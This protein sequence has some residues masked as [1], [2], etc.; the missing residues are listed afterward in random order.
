MA[1]GR[2]LPGPVAPS[3]KWTIL[4]EDVSTSR[5]EA[6]YLFV[7]SRRPDAFDA[8]DERLLR[9][10][11]AHA[12]VALEK[13]RVYAS[14]R[15]D[16]DKV[17]RT[18]SGMLDA[19]ERCTRGHSDRV[20]DHAVAIG[21]EL[22]LPTQDLEMLRFAGLL[23]DIGKLGI[24]EEIILKPTE[25][26]DDE[27]AQVRRHAEIGASLVEQM[28]FLGGIAPVILHH[29]ERWDGRGYPDGI[30][31]EDI[32]LLARVLAVA[33]A[34]DA[35]TVDRAYSK[36][37][38]AGTARAELERGAGSQFDPRVV[39]AFLAVLARGT[40]AAA[41]GLYSPPDDG[42]RQLPA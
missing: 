13:S 12:S 14:L 39:A 6:G 42:R 31:G 41:R 27:L 21:T 10:E 25:L 2:L 5:P 26:S 3:A 18:L 38:P 23:H 20:V 30:A 7:A 8:T 34:F 37:L 40:A 17:V 32:P 24:A 36:A 29:H 22:G 35:M 28:E 19:T 16:L 4:A 9:A 33:D 15:T 11:A 1:D